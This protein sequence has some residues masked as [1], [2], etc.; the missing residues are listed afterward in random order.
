M[1]ATSPDDTFLKSR[2]GGDAGS[3]RETIDAL[4]EYLESLQTLNR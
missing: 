4:V 1:L 2:G 3:V